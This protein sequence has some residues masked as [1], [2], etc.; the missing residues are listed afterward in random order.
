MKYIKHL[1]IIVVLLLI[2]LVFSRRVVEEGFSSNIP[3]HIWTYWDS[4]TITN[5][6]VLT[7]IDSW[8]KHNPEY[9]ITIL[10]PSNVY[11]YID[12]DLKSLKMNDSPQ[13]EADIIRAHVLQK[14]GGVW[15][16]ASV[17]MVG[18]LDF[19]T[20]LDREY[21]GFK[22]KK[23]SSPGIPMVENWFFATVPNGK[24]ITAWKNE[25]MKAE[26]FPSIRDA[27]LALRKQG[28]KLTAC[29]DPEYLF[30]HVAAQKVLQLDMTKEEINKQL[31]LIDA[32]ETAFK[33][34]ANGTKKGLESICNGDNDSKIIKFTRHERRFLENNP[35][36]SECIFN[37]KKE[38]KEKSIFNFA[39]F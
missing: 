16:D 27:I 7:C 3:R 6:V 32:D 23:E 37:E 2:F 4:E 30:M 20:N 28:V 18:P 31:Y 8:K 39:G 14:H 5:K 35:G 29:S 38:P 36:L 12:I 25:Y 22:L 15:I 10:N 9:E 26:T 34:L 33:Y 17:Y 24:F 19:P 1:F 21:Y 13:H 11:S